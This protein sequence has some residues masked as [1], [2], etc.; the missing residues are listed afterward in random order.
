[1]ITAKEISDCSNIPQLK[2]LIVN[3]IKEYQNKHKGFITDYEID[4]L[5]HRIVN[6]LKQ[7]N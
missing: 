7:E 2:C 1:M 5:P 4:L 6:S 3:L